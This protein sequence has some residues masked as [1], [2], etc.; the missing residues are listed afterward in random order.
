MFNDMQLLQI[1][2]IQLTY[3]YKHKKHFQLHKQ[4]VLKSCRRLASAEPTVPTAPPM[5]LPNPKP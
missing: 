2:R 5:R 3:V 4:T 1:N